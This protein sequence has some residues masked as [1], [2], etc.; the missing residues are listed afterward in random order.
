MT[1][2]GICL[3]IG[4]LFFLVGTVQEIR[5]RHVELGRI[6]WW[7]R[8]SLIVLGA[9]LLG[10]GVW[11]LLHPPSAPAV[12]GQVKAIAP[13]PSPTGIPSA[14]PTVAKAESVPTSGSRTARVRARSIELRQPPGNSQPVVA[15]PDPIPVDRPI[16]NVQNNC[17]ISGGINT[18]NQS[19]ICVHE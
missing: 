19:P 12:G 7:V 10:I 13:S 3:I 18:G 9:A 17:V 6:A 14:T 15:K 8:L 16:P 5:S 2:T 4:A 1:D 11:K